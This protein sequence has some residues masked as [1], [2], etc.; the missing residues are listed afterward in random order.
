[1][2]ERRKIWDRHAQRNNKWQKMK[3]NKKVL[4]W[5]YKEDIEK[6]KFNLNV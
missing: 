1:M 5:K 2:N 3:E 4:K 6:E